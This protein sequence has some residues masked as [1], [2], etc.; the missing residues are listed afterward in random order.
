MSSLESKVDPALLAR[1]LDW[2]SDIEAFEKHHAVD[3]VFHAGGFCIPPF[4]SDPETLFLLAL[5]VAFWFWIDDRSDKCLLNESSPFDWDDFIGFVEGI[6]SGARSV[7]DLSPEKR[8]V[9]RLSELLKGSTTSAAGHDFW[10]MTVCRVSRG[11]RFEETAHR[12]GHVPSYLECIEYCMRSTAIPNILATASL[13]C[14]IDRAARQAEMTVWDIERC[15]CIHQRLLNDLK[16]Y[17]AERH[18]GH[19]GKITNLVLLMERIV[20]I[21]KAVRFVTNDLARIENTLM[22][23]AER[24]GREDPFVQ[25]ILYAKNNISKWYGLAP[26]RY[27][28]M[29]L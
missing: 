6:T 12:N 3:G 10:L 18:E 29:S 27:Q 26:A 16:T 20:G 25:L 22:E 19:E 9:L 17:R 15:F 14:E 4:D 23:L 28:N 5:D 7:E 8:F 11:M 24:L 1:V 21:D 13:V 2:A